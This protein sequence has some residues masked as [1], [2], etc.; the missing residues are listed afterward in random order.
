L[1]FRFIETERKVFEVRWLTMRKPQEG[2]SLVELLIV[3]TIILI[4]AAIAV[5]NLLRSRI[6]ANES[7]AVSAIRTINTAETT[8]QSTWGSGFAA[9][10][11]NLGGPAPC[12]VAS[13]AAACI[14]DPLL[15]NPPFTKS[16]YIFAAAGTMPLAGVL[17]GFE[18]NAT[19][20]TVQV[21][22]V[23]GYCANQT[24]LIQFITPGNAPIGL[25]P[26]AC[27]GVANVPGTSGP[28]N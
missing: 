5:P 3:V 12:L 8:Y 13:A 17:N 26:G 10:L 2:F 20:A 1:S 4:V 16:G 15:S 24:G 14:T 22:G 18:V 19:P 23:R 25:G 21:T 28:V 27:A 6:A 7:S 11:A 9:T